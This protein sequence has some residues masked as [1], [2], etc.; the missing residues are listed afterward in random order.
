MGLAKLSYEIGCNRIG[1]QHQAGS[2]SLLT[3]CCY[4]KMREQNELFTSAHFD[5]SLN[6]IFGIGLGYL[7][8]SLNGYQQRDY[9]NYISTDYYDE[10]AYYPD[11]R[12]YMN[13]GSPYIYGNGGGGHGHGALYQYLHH[14]TNG[15][16]MYQPE[17]QQHQQ[18]RY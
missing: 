1:P 13:Q 4:F 14:H 12:M 16:M 7:K 11:N 10:R 15:Y 9:E 3:L 2:D 5:N 17:Q 8:N 6:I 18:R